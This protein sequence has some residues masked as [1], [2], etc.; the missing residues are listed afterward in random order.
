MERADI[1]ESF[2]RDLVRGE[3][4]DLA[5]LKI[6]PLPARAGTTS[7]GDAATSWPVRL[8]MTER[9][10][11]LLGSQFRWLPEL[12]ER[13]PLPVPTS[14]SAQHRNEIYQA[15]GSVGHASLP[16]PVSVNV[17]PAELVQGCWDR[18][19]PL[20]VEPL[21][22]VRHLPLWRAVKR[23]CPLVPTDSGR[24]CWLVPPS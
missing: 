7:S 5:D 12:A 11:A 24:H 2:V 19:A 21:S 8:P 4:P 16:Q 6:R 13:L 22:T 15:D 20:A 17:C 9:A 14:P 23:Y 1:D 18:R 3:Y 10:P